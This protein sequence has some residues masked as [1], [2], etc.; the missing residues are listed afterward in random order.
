M[1]NSILAIE[2]SKYPEGETGLRYRSNW[3]QVNW[4]LK[5]LI[6][7]ITTVDCGRFQMG[8]W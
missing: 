4:F 2:W 8:K 7:Q 6:Q 3:N 5:Q 1:C